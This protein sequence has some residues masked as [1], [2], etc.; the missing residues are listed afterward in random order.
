MGTAHQH[1]RARRLPRL[2]TFGW[3]QLAIVVSG[4]VLVLIT[5]LILVYPSLY[6]EYIKQF[7]IR[8]FEARYSFETGNVRVPAWSGQP[9]HT[10]WGIVSVAPDGA[11]NRLGVR[12]GDIPFAYH[13]GVADMYYA[14]QW[15]A[16]GHASSF[17]VSNASDRHLGRAGLRDVNLPPVP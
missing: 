8:Q 1:D 15:A 6:V 9:A 7:G 5:I 12:S 17:Q 2:A 16:A 4:V 13:G 14:L 10:E 11:F 3:P